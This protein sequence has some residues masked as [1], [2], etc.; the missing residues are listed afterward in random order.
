MTHDF[1]VG[2][3]VLLSSYDAV[4]HHWSVPKNEWDRLVHLGE[5]RISMIDDGIIRVE[6]SIYGFFYRAFTHVDMFYNAIQVDDLL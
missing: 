5:L 1:S 6:E 2:D 3:H 4:C